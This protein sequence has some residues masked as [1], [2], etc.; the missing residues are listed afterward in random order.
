[1]NKENNIKQESFAAI[2]KDVYFSYD[3]GKTWILNG[4]NLKIKY[5]ERVV[6]VGLNGSGKSTLSKILSGLI[7]PDS[8]LVQLCGNK[9]FDL[10]HADSN[11]YKIARKSIGTLF[12]NPEDQIITTISEDDIAFGL[13][14]LCVKQSNMNEMI[15]NAL[16]SVRMENHRYDDPSDMSGGQQQKIALASTIVTKP[17]LLIF[18]E[19]TSMLDYKSLQYVN[20]LFDDLQ[21]RGFTIVHITHKFDECVYA[22][23]ILLVNKGQIRDISS[24][25]LKEYYKN[26]IDTEYAKKCENQPDNEKETDTEKNQDL[27]QNQTNDETFAIEVSNLNVSY[28]KRAKH[29]INNYSL[30]VKHGEIVAITGE[31]GSGKSTLAKT[32]CGLL[33]Y[34][35]GTVLIQGIPLNAKEN[36]TNTK[37]LRQTIGYVMQCPEQQLFAQTVFEDVSYGPKNFGLEGEKLN[38]K[39]NETLKML[40][41]EHLA[42]FSP[43]ELSGGQ[44]R[45][46]AIAGVLAYNPKIL[47]LDEPSAGLDFESAMRLRKILEDLHKKGITIVLITHD[48]NEAKALK[49][50][51]IT[52]KTEKDDESKKSTIKENRHFTDNIHSSSTSTSNSSSTSPFLSS[53]DPRVTLISCFILIFSAFRV[54]NYSQLGI[55]SIATLILT[56]FAR[57]QF[58]KLIS[59]LHVLISIF[60]FSSILN[61]FIVKTGRILFYLFSIPITL[62]GV[63]FTILFSTRLSLAMLIGLTVILTFTP[64]RLTQACASIIS[65]LK[66]FKLPTQE[67]A[68]IMTL[69]L[70]FLPTLSKEAKAISIAQTARGGSIKN[71]S[72]K[73]RLQA[74]TSL[75]IPGFAGVIRHAYNL[76]LALD[77]RCYIPQEARTHFH[78][79]KIRFRDIALAIF[80]III[81]ILIAKTTNIL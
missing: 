11:A 38:N 66:V 2:L 35:S 26:A 48:M 22:D 13:E 32:I 16:E 63:N 25:E 45:L 24:N 78:V 55:L 59:F 71:G 4:I 57:I 75:I 3:S 33:K 27:L 52:I 65:P 69:A 62:D 51:I 76:G 36:K 68:F 50:R 44:Q 43:F 1:M 8:G 81:T 56:I 34:D 14:N 37:K 53:F 10:D 77:S 15:L 30:K 39:V 7:A 20:S 47:V 70:R 18:D 6:I 31:N 80:S 64:T 17:K 72:L 42:Q 73:K 41:I 54:T 40:H 74:M 5:G 58:S 21:K 19:P 46:V 60:I 67:I 28:S 49:A 12:Q 29:V 23:R 79:L 61:I 9:V